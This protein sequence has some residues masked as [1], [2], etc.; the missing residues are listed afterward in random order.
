[1][2]AIPHPLHGISKEFLTG[3]FCCLQLPLFI[4]IT[5]LDSILV[6]GASIQFGFTQFFIHFDVVEV[7]VLDVKSIMALS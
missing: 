1:M 3:L 2:S 4:T 7:L 6:F 5:V